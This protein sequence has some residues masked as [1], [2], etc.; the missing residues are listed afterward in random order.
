MTVVCGIY[1][2][3]TTRPIDLPGMRIEPRTCDYSLAKEWA[4]DLDTYQLTAILTGALISSDLIFQLEATLSFVEH[5][6]VVISSPLEAEGK[7]LFTQFPPSIQTHRRNNG[8]GATIQEDTFFHTSRSLF[9][10]KT[11]DRLQ[12]KEFCEQ[13]KFNILFFK[14]VEPFR[15][16]KPF[17]E[18][19]YF[20]LYSG[21]ES[22]ARSV[23][24]D[25]ISRNSSKPICELLTRYGFDVQIEKPDDLPRRWQPTPT[26]AMPFFTIAN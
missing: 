22:Y 15:Q 16:R 24:E 1:G 25:H 8:G 14:S 21:L 7:D 9:I 6:D 3:Q 12:N 19:T 2:Y 20:L 13:T 26:S 4:R 11:L 5:L 17:I 10:S 23:I 18:I